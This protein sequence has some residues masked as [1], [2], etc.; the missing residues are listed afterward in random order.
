MKK[1]INEHIKLFLDAH[2]FD[3]IPQG[4]VTFL[5]GLYSR[6][7]KDPHIELYVGSYDRENAV[8]LLN[9]DNFIH[10]KYNSHSSLKRLLLEIPYTLKK[11]EIDY[12]HFQYISPLQKKCKYIVTIHDLLF[13]EF[14]NEFPLLYKIRNS[15]LFWFTAQRADLITTVSNYSKESIH[16]F[17]KINKKKILITPNSVEEFSG[18]T[19][20]V[21]ELKNKKFILYVSRIEPR[22]N[23]A[24]LIKLWKSLR[25]Y[26]D[27]ISLV[28]V[29]SEG[30]NDLNFK[31]EIN[32]L[33]NDELGFFYW[34]KKVPNEKLIWL[35][36]NCSLF[37]YPSLGEGFGIPPLEAAVNGAKVLCSNTTAMKEFTF[38]IKNDLGFDPNIDEEF[39]SKMVKMLNSSEHYPFEKIK[40]EILTFYNW[41]FIARKLVIEIVNDHNK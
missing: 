39:K 41:D 7:I 13:L 34:L 40:D 23:Q 28:I 17:F 35:Y 22:K 2:V 6:I 14:P 9:S 8:K 5:S 20:P 15:L 4:T 11:N 26:L 29:G 12:A 37:V 36:R 18:R 25:F 16:H 27:E 30:V 1:K 32:Y 21:S 3:G 10:I 19:E 33:T 31:R 38:F 24:K